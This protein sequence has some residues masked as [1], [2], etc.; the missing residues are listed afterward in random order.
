MEPIRIGRVPAGAGTPD[1]FVTVERDDSPH[2]R[3]D[4]YVEYGGAFCELIT[5]AGFVVLGWG[6][7][8]HLVDPAR[9]AVRR[10]DC[11]GYF[12]HLYPS[13]AHLLIASASELICVNQAGE[14]LWRRAGLG[15]DGVIVDRADDGFIEGQGEWDPPGGWRPFRLS[16]ATGA[17]AAG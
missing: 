4:A 2:T 13:E 9:R 3:I 16:L 1:A 7:A 6:D 10:V 12:G 17:L 14:P 5:W 11:D 8:V 15:L